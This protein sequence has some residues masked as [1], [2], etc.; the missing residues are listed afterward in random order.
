MSPSWTDNLQAGVT[1]QQLI[2]WTDGCIRTQSLLHLHATACLTDAYDDT[3]AAAAAASATSAS[4]FSTL[5]SVLQLLLR[6]STA[7]QHTQQLTRKWMQ[8]ASHFMTQ[9]ADTGF[10]AST[11]KCAI[12]VLQTTLFTF[13]QDYV[14]AAPDFCLP[15]ITPGLTC[16]LVLGCRFQ[17]ALG[18]YPQPVT[19]AGGA[20]V[21]CLEPGECWAG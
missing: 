6:V 3:A 4:T 21:G 1:M 11:K 8:P 17:G 9:P 15:S 13:K 19:D 7:V 14:G 10:A 2:C 18:L 20:I 12:V 5:R 16:Q